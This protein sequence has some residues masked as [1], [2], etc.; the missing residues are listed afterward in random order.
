MNNRQTYMRLLNEYPEWITK[1]QLYRICHISKR[2]AKYLLDSGLI[3]CKDSGKKTRRYLI[4]MKSVVDYLLDRDSHPQNYVLPPEWRL[5]STSSAQPRL[6]P[7]IL[8]KMYRFF[9]DT[10]TELDDVLTVTA[11]SDATG[12]CRERIYKW[13]KSEHLLSF[14]TDSMY[15]IPKQYLIDFLASSYGCNLNRKSEWHKALLE[16]FKM[17][18]R[19]RSTGGHSK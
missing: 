17:K 4:Q 9:T 8:D 14:Q 15:R 16:S 5:P 13:L 7:E 18:R 10:L 6:T 3:P 2:K 1:D 19:K 12:Y 11:A